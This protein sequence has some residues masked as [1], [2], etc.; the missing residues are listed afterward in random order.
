MFTHIDFIRSMMSENDKMCLLIVCDFYTK[1]G[2]R[3]TLSFVKR[4]DYKV[5]YLQV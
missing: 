4:R 5:S 1:S 3:D 2:K